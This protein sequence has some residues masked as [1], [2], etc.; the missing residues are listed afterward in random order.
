MGSDSA[1]IEIIVLAVIAGFL[2][3]RLRSVLGK[4][5]G[6]ERPRYE[7]AERYVGRRETGETNDNVTPFPGAKT[8]DAEPPQLHGPASKLQG[9]DPNFDE[10]GFIAGAREAFRMILA[11][12]AS[13]DRDTLRALA[14]NEVYDA[15]EGAISGRESRDETL[16]ATLIGIQSARIEDVETVGSVAR[17]TVRFE[18]EQTNVTRNAEGQPID[19]APNQVETIIDLWTFERDMSSSDPNWKLIETE[20]GD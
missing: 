13:G 15:L 11:A 5:H 2:I 10:A 8:V 17:V 4:R 12:Y 19:G 6:H 14:N 18:S 3:L 9:L 16:D 20:P 7:D 1:L